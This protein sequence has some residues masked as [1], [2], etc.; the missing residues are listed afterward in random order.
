MTVLVTVASRHGATAEIGEQIAETLRS[1]GL[2]TDVAPPERIVS[3]AMYD[4]VIIGSGIYLG[5]M[6]APA[7]DFIS[8]HVDELSRRPTW[9]FGSGPVTP[10][11]EGDDV[12]VAEARRLGEQIG[13]RDVRL[14][15]GALK[16]EGLS[17]V[18]RVSVSM[19][20]SPWG[21]YRPWEDITEWAESIAREIREASAVPAG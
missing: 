20:H 21:D 10:I 11:K 18:E 2:E 19:I 17:F 6:L 3:L 4:A 16:K 12:D 14:F 5:R 15:A 8:A 13:A 9:I 1:H 7:R